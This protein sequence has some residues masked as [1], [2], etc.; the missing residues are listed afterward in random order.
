M[1][2][3]RKTTSGSVKAA[4]RIPARRRYVRAAEDDDAQI[5]ETINVDDVDTDADVAPEATDLVFE[6]QDVADLVSAVTDAPVDVDVA[7]DGNSIDFTVGDDEDAEVYT[8]EADG[9]EEVLESVRTRKKA[10]KASRRPA[11]RRT[12]TASRRAYLRRPASRR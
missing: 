7:D 3:S 2:I 11:S 9:N 8:V 12:V 4:N 6:V 1:K 5:D 10:V